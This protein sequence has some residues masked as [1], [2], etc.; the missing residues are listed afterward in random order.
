M[1]ISVRGCDHRGQS[2]G[3]QRGRLGHCT[4]RRRGDG[5]A[6]GLEEGSEVFA[7]GFGTA[8]HELPVFGIIGLWPFG[9]GKI[10]LLGEDLA[11]GFP[12]KPLLELY[13]DDQ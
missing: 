11:E 3:I 4:G 2:S 12:A 1:G 6:P 7:G 10:L 5:E 13:M 8:D 9:A